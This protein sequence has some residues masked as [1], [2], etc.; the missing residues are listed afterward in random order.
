[1]AAAAV[2]VSVMHVC[3][4]INI[5][6]AVVAMGLKWDQTLLRRKELSGFPAGGNL[7]ENTWSC[8][9]IVPYEKIQRKQMD[10]NVEKS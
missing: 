5:G 10:R 3:R 9:W 7:T 8:Y 1:M 4:R 2:P 6:V